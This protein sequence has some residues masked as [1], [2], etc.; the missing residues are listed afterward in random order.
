MDKPRTLCVMGTLDNKASQEVYRI[1]DSLESQGFTADAYEPH[2][3]FGIYTG[4]EEKSLIQWI[5][6]IAS[7]H[8]SFQICFNHFGFFPDARLCFLAP[9]SNRSLLAL[10]SNIHKKYDEHCVDKG[11]LYSLKQNNWVPHIT[12][13]V[14][15]PAQEA[16]ALSIFWESFSPFAAEIIRLKITSSDMVEEVGVFELKAG[17]RHS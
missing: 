5:G 2:I 13:A 4:L 8:K 6:K 17:M 1:K 14:V 9:G 10:H 3:T 11:Y 15:E 16:K 12:M 7:Q